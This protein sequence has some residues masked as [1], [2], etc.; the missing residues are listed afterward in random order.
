[1]PGVYTLCA[2]IAGACC[3]SRRVFVASVSGLPALA[4]LCAK[5]CHGGKIVGLIPNMETPAPPA[6]SALE[7][8]AAETGAMEAPK[9]DTVRESSTS[10]QRESDRETESPTHNRN[11][12]TEIHRHRERT[13]AITHCWLHGWQA[14]SLPQSAAVVAVARHHPASQA[15][16]AVA[17]YLSRHVLAREERE[18]LLPLPCL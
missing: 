3:W 1:M 7:E 10:I 4:V 13:S 18:G 14:R 9:E 16:H 8:A 11:R 6:T 12:G 17:R 15:S 2:S 5:Y